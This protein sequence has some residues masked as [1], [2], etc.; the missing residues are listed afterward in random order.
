MQYKAILTHDHDQKV[1]L[2]Q[3]EI[4]CYSARQ[5]NKLYPNGGYH[6]AGETRAGNKKE[7]VADFTAGQ[8]TFKVSK[9]GTFNHMTNRCA[10]YVK[11]GEDQY[12]ALYKSRLPF[13]L[14]LIA[15]IALLAFLL[16]VLIAG[17]DVPV[18][19]PDH[20]LPEVDQN[21][22]AID[23]ESPL[24]DEHEEEPGFS[25]NEEGGGAL[26]MIY[27]LEADV[28]LGKGQIGIYF[29]NPTAST[30]DVVL[31]MYIVSEG[32]EYLAARSGRIQ[33]GYELKT[34]ELMTEKV[35]LSEGNYNGLYKVHCYDPVTGE[36]ALVAPE[37]T[38]LKVTVKQ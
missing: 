37:I 15:L 14:A 1:K 31:E 4:L 30:H 11:V 8:T 18:V 2:G 24:E 36:L 26:S 3:E 22:V 16:S 7:A 34:M 38:D 21:A 10:G 9:E 33:A 29:K 32:E 12:L 17:P 13:L 6:V 28:S 19:T 25:E 27:T 23:P 35:I 5:L 20:P